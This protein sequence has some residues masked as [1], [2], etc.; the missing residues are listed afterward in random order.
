M[1]CLGA[2]RMGTHR[3]PCAPCFV[4]GG[5]RPF[6]GAPVWRSQTRGAMC[7]CVSTAVRVLCRGMGKRLLAGCGSAWGLQG[8]QAAACDYVCVIQAGAA[9]G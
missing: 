9:G 5:D 4:R 8:L 6:Q 7:A 1:C 3:A 2:A